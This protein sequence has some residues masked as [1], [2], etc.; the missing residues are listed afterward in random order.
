MLSLD[1]I[2]EMGAE[3]LDLIAA[4]RRQRR[5]SDPI[6][7]T[8]NRNRIERPHLQVRVIAVDEE[9]LPGTGDAERRGQAMRL[10][11]ER[12]QRSLSLVQIARLVE[13]PALE[14]ERLVGAQAIGARSDRADGERLG[15]RQFSGETLERTAAREMLAFERPLVDLGGDHFR[16]KSDGRQKGP[17]ARALRGQ[18]QWLT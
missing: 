8:R 18:N 12:S 5:R 11:R 10:A 6:E 15:L 7:V 3:A 4:D 17:A 9:R 13:Y 2:H 1:A 14:R 16:V